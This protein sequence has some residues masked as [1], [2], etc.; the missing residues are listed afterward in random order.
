M[1]GQLKQYVTT[2]APPPRG[3]L[4]FRDYQ[5]QLIDENLANLSEF[6]Q[7][8]AE[9]DD[10]Y[11]CW[12]KRYYAYLTGINVE[13]V[14]PGPDDRDLPKDGTGP[15]REAVYQFGLQLKNHQDPKRLFKEILQSQSYQNVLFGKAGGN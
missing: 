6:G 9:L 8:L 4:Y 10:P 12:A 13:I 7:K 11:V 14:D 1:V 5:G 15:H 3:K 2:N